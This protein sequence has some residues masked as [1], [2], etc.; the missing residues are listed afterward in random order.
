MALQKHLF[1]DDHEKLTMA[2]YQVFKRG[3]SD[4]LGIENI[5]GIGFGFKGF[6]PDNASA[7]VRFLEKTRSL[8]ILTY[9][10]QDWIREI[11]KRLQ[12]E[13][14]IK[15]FVGKKAEPER[16]QKEFHIATVMKSLGYADVATD[17]VEISQFRPSRS[18]KTIYM[19]QSGG[20]ATLPGGT[21][22]AV[23]KQK[24][25]D[26]LLSCAH[27]FVD[28]RSMN[29]KDIIQPS[30]INGGL[31]PRD[32]V[33]TVNSYANLDFGGH[34]NN[35]DA[36]TASIYPGVEPNYHILGALGPIQASVRNPH[37]CE[38]VWKVGAATSAT[39]GVVVSGA[40]DIPG[41]PYPWGCA[42][43][44]EV[45]AVA[46]F[47]N[48]FPPFPFSAS[49]DSGSIVVSGQ[50]GQIVGLLFADSPKYYNALICK[51]VEV[52]H[53]LEISF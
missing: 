30:S 40:I 21:I 22:G 51:S 16:V 23:V 24:G 37:T 25:S 26:A 2:R 17:V 31:S 34:W 6:P 19:G 43:F 50:T 35:I 14:C 4:P 42:N 36:A 15:V 32:L 11:F 49:G 20:N 5:W 41:L 12:P 29:N 48:S 53:E 38:Y 45:Y 28:F 33:G 18:G 39:Q 10:Y 13:R 8:D 46:P 7:F 44:R 27:V 52:A 47:W 1:L 9:T 3:Y